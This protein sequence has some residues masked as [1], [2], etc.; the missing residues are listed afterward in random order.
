MAITTNEAIILRI[1]NASEDF[2][3]FAS[4]NGFEIEYRESIGG[5]VRR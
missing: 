5:Y 4:S 1:C 2:K 3:E